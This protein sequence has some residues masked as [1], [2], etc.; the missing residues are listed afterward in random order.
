MII[1]EL[2]RLFRE[3]VEAF[4]HTQNAIGSDFREDPGMAVCSVYTNLLRIEFLFHKKEKVILPVCTLFCRVYLQKNGDRF[5]HLPEILDMLP[6]GEE[7]FRCWYFPY[8]ESEERMRA[9]FGALSGG[10]AAYLPALTELANDPQRL[11]EAYIRQWNQWVQLYALTEN[12]IPADEEKRQEFILWMQRHCERYGILPHY[13]GNKA[14]FRFLKGDPAGAAAEYR[15]AKPRSR[16]IYEERLIRFLQSPACEGYRAIDP[17]CF[18]QARAK[19]YKSSL[20]EFGWGAVYGLVCLLA[21]G[22]LLYAVSAAV[23]AVLTRG[24]VYSIPLPWYMGLLLGGL[25]A[26]FGAIALR[27]PLARLLRRTQAQEVL[28]FDEIINGRGINRFAGILF[29]VT[30]A[31]SLFGSLLLPFGTVC[32]YPDR[33]AY[34]EAELPLNR[35]EYRYEEIL[36]VYRMEGR[37]NDYGDWIDRSSYGVKFRDGTLLD[38]DWFMVDEEEVEARV[39]P[40]LPG[41]P[42]TVRCEEEIP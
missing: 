12:M 7:D 17:A 6:G 10:L 18:V 38:F 16:M 28:A 14:Y 3:Q 36:G 31:L 23:H 1:R 9:C 40:L 19:F 4:V 26:I 5:F 15:K 13:T 11:R 32:F 37:Y 20:R 39:L 21:C 33:L 22:G 30:L 24:T 2:V 35:Q 25:P 41:E 42:V 8:I 29:G 27:R 34:W